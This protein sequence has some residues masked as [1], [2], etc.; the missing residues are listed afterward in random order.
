MK[1]FY[2]LIALLLAWSTQGFSQSMLISGGNDFAAMIC[3]EGQVMT[4]G[5]DMGGTSFTQVALPPG[6]SFS[7]ITAGSGSHIVAVSCNNIAYAWGRNDKFQCGSTTPSPVT[8]PQP[9]PKVSGTLGYDINGNPGGD[10]L[11]DVKTVAASSAG[12]FALLNDGKVVGWGGNESTG[13]KWVAANTPTPFY[14]TYPNGNPVEN[15]IHIAGGDN[16]ILITVDN[17]GDGLG[18][19]YS[20]GSWNG[21]GGGAS[22]TEY[23]AEPVL[24]GDSNNPV[25]PAVPAETLSNIRMSGLM[26]VGGF[27]VDV[28]GYVWGWGNA[29]GRGA[30]GS[31][32]STAHNYAAKV[33]SGEYKEIS[34][35][36]YLTDVKEV[37]GGNMHGM[38]ITKEGYVVGWGNE[39]VFGKKS[40]STNGP[41]FLTYP[42]GSRVT[43]AV[44][45]A[46]GDNFGFMVNANN[47]YFAI[48][49]GS[50]GVLGTGNTNNSSC[51][52][53]IT[54]SNSCPPID[55][56]PEVFLLPIHTMC[57]TESLTLNSEFV[58]PTGKEADYYFS[59]YFNGERL[60]S[61]TKTS[62][63]AERQTDE[64]NTPKPE[65]T[66][67]GE[68]KV[69]A[70]YIGTQGP[71]AAVA[72]DS[73]QTTVVY[74]EMP[75]A[76]PET[77]VCFENPLEPNELCFELEAKDNIEKTFNVYKEAIGGNSITTITVPATGKETLCLQSD[78]ASIVTRGND[79]YYDIYLEESASEE[80]GEDVDRT[81][82]GGA[83]CTTPSGGMN[84]NWNHYILVTAYTKVLLESLD[85][86]VTTLEGGGT[87]SAVIYESEPGTGP[88][89][90][91]IPNTAEVI[92]SGAAV[93]ISSIGTLTLPINYEWQGAERGISYFIGIKVTPAGKKAP[94]ISETYN[95]T[96][97]QYDDSGNALSADYSIM[98]G[99]NK[100]N[101]LKLVTNIQFKE[102]SSSA[103]EC[104]RAKL[105]AKLECCEH[106]LEHDATSG[107]QI[108]TDE[109]EDNPIKEIRFEFGGGATNVNFDPPL[110][111]GMSYRIIDGCTIAINGV[112][113]VTTGDPLCY[114]LTTTGDACS[115]KSAEIRFAVIPLPVELT[116]FEAQ[117]VAPNVLVRWETKSETNNDYFTLW[118][119]RDG[120]SFEQIA[121]IAGAGNTSIPR[122]YSFV[123]NNP[124]S[125]IAYYRLQQTDFDG[126][127]TVH[128]VIPVNFAPEQRI[129]TV[130]NSFN[131]G[132]TTL[133][134][135]FSAAE[136]SNVIRV[137]S[138]K[139]ELIYEQ[140][141]DA[142]I[143]QQDITLNLKSG[144]YIVRNFYNNKI[145]SLTIKVAY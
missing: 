2:I 99:S 116:Q 59:W 43:D 145:S 68:Y 88:G 109:I 126:T 53:P 73:A 61:S 25:N 103:T 57:P 26:D 136:Y 44:H 130:V 46:R 52:T 24:K 11:G 45:I 113:P 121:H 67:E 108:Q 117:A 19:L 101:Q 78:E 94:V 27:A 80:D 134:C 98:Y 51:F 23:F 39:D 120:V 140:N 132:V 37:V 63:A 71:C 86:T 47:E 102:L 106:S 128:H 111:A 18:E 32:L 89:A 7:Q 29:A 105:R 95:C 6:L 142:G 4:W 70:E 35:E 75:I 14:I 97:P 69:V 49:K 139:G 118:R 122:H 79:I 104:G 90:F 22:A 56:T 110:P 42:D 129:F 3:G 10:Y 5:A 138:V 30:T 91:L 137:Y 119:S 20:L 9:I 123:D 31:G 107:A 83:P 81:L 93:T 38:A 144:I 100:S 55:P 1:R 8:S 15:V 48:G 85:I 84:S 72:A 54:L 87:V 17:D 62:S 28:D 40:G 34:G 64:W 36:D 141:I 13:G 127:T 74:Y 77:T 131:K 33:I 115:T 125:G 82:L 16:N 65:V 60:N 135:N 143:K 133:Q 21:R 12:S 112:H 66:D 41:I 124:I 50:N 92:H 76:Y 58:I 114:T 96:L